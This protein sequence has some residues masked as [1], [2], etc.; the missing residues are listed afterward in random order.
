MNKTADTLRL[1]SNTRLRFASE[2]GRLVCAASLAVALGVA[3]GLWLFARLATASSKPRASTR[4]TQAARASVAATEQ[5]S[6]ELN[7]EA[8]SSSSS[9]VITPAPRAEV[10]GASRNVAPAKVNREK[11]DAATAE[12]TVPDVKPAAAKRAAAPSPCALYAS[13]VSLSLRGGGSAPLVLG[14]P[15][16]VT[17]TTPDWA[18]IAVFNEGRTG[19]GERAWTRYIVKSVSDRA[20]NYTLRLDSPCGSQTVHVKVAPR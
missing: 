19:A 18:D 12:E 6:V 16:R 10:L 17:V 13:A 1:S 2:T 8:S 11:R 9:G 4:Q 3:C 15:G 20:G 5:A 14:G 7:H